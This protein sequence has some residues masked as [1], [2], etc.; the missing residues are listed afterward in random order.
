MTCPVRD[1]GW[2]ACQLLLFH[3][4]THLL[5]LGFEDKLAGKDCASSFAWNSAPK[6][7][8]DKYANAIAYPMAFHIC[9]ICLD[10]QKRNR[11]SFTKTLIDPQGNL[12]KM[13]I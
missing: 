13:E 8:R 1:S 10:N 3:N 12:I 5:D 11:K 6:S 4:E 7:A 2:Y 9:N